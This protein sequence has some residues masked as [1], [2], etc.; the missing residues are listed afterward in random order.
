MIER[1]NTGVHF[2]TTV[3]LFNSGPYL[4]PIQHVYIFAAFIFKICIGLKRPIGNLTY[5]KS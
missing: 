5:T 1:L 3:L 4:F 2:Y